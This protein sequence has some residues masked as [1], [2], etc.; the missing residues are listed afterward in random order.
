M[1]AAETSIKLVLTLVYAIPALKLHSELDD[2]SSKAALLSWWDKKYLAD[3]VVLQITRIVVFPAT[4]VEEE[5]PFSPLILAS[6]YTV[7]ILAATLSFYRKKTLAT[8]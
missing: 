8:R 2:E 5:L 6:D 7:G 3:F 4:G 1:K